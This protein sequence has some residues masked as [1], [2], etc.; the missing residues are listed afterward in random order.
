MAATRGPSRNNA[1]MVKDL[2]RWVGD[3]VP[4]MNAVTWIIAGT[5]AL[6]L[7]IALIKQLAKTAVLLALLI[8]VGLF[9]MIGRV[10]NWSF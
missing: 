2:V 7:V 4:Q 10:E 6:V 9:L 5:L 3:V 1:V 8:G